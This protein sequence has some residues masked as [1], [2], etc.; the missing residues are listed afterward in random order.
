MARATPIWLRLVPVA[1]CVVLVLLLLGPA[2][3]PGFLLSYDLVWVPDLALRPDF[4]GTGTG[5]PRAVPSDA[6]VAILDEVVPGMLLEKVVLVGSLTAAGLGAARLA[7]PRLGARLVAVSVA[8]WNP[9]VVERLWLG[10]W[11]VLVG[12]ACLP[13]LAEA[14]M[15]GRRT[16]Q[17]PAT[18]PLLLPVASLSASAGLTSAIVVLALGIS[19]R[20]THG[21]RR[22]SGWLVASVVAANAP[23]VVA[24]LLHAPTAEIAPS[25]G[26]FGLHGDGLP[27]PLAALSLA[28]VWN[29]EVVPGTRETAVLPALFLVFLLVVV[30]LGWTNAARRLGRRDLGGLVG[31]WAAG[32]GVALLTW[33]APGAVDAVAAR[34]PGAGLVRDGTRTLALGLPLVVVLAGAAANEIVD[35]ATR[36]AQRALGLMFAVAIAVFPVAVLPDAAWGISGELRPADYPDDWAAARAALTAADPPG[37]L[38]V[39]PAGAYRAPEWNHGRTVLDPLG[40][41]LPT[42]WV[43]DDDLVVSGVLIPGEDPR[44]DLVEQALARPAGER[45]T[46]L[47]RLGIGVVAV[48]KDASPPA[49]RA[50][51]VPGTALV[52]GETLRLVVL[53]GPVREQERPPGWLL[54]LG[55]AWAA[56]AGCFLLGVVL[57]IRSH[58]SG[59]RIRRDNY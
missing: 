8:V 4:L 14:A 48:E 53:D 10:H 49:P 40:R 37:D 36:R 12:Y 24:G 26:Q 17:V 32:F 44:G 6:V 15:R 16:H 18:L 13:W 55:P 33:L 23:W 51:A 30:A 57:S 52:D 5:L 35:R 28:G 59:R 7:G 38:L 22:T 3:G 9:F 34:I 1:W 56:Y 19:V 25:T 31:C 20:R 11:T 54:A 42:D 50:P 39:L 58:R 47:A 29:A 41:Y 46:A 21:S 2:L 43:A 27:A 45:A